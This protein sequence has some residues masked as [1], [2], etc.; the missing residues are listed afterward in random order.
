M[1]SKRVTNR[2]SDQLESKK[3]ALSKILKL[4]VTERLILEDTSIAK[5]AATIARHVGL[6][7]SATSRSLKKLAAR[8]IVRAHPAIG[9][10]KRLIWKETVIQ[11]LR[12]LALLP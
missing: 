10:D 7:E 12:N 9:K 11:T 4:S 8:G 2:F 3:A 1:E 6:S 5:S